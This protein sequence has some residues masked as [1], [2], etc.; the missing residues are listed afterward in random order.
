MPPSRIIFACPF[1]RDQIAGGIRTTYRHAAMLR[2]AGVDALVFSPDGHPVWFGSDALVESD[3]GF[4][5]HPGDVVVINEI[6]SDVT[7]NYLRLGTR[8]QMF[9]QNQFYV[10]G[11]HL[12]LAD[13]AALGIEQV[14]GSSRSIADFFRSVYGIET[15]D[16]V[17][18]AV[19]G[20]LFRPA[21]KTLSIAYVPRKLPFEAEFIKTAFQRKFPAWRGVPWRAID[22][23]TENRTAE[24]LSE[25]A[26]FLALGHRDSFGLPA[27]EA[28]ASGCA[29]VG[30]H[31][32]GGLE[33]AT[34]DNG[35]W[36]HS[37]QL[38]ECVEA[39]GQVVG[40]VERGDPR[41]AAQVATGHATAAGY[42]LIAARR[43]LLRHFGITPHEDA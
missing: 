43:A 41:I 34:A 10:F 17:P 6:I 11:R 27:V 29:V 42:S 3:P 19:D 12:G 1:P 40:D 32:T 20:A 23:M 25:A 4:R 7:L 38:L 24:I 15:M 30:F 18:Y 13:H 36:F 2:A 28:M 33:F 35:R 9:C 16:V 26:V 39:L 37:D 8:K 5:F 31:G 14:Y 22:G 21:A